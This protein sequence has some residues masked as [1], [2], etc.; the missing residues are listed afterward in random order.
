MYQPCSE[1]SSIGLQAAMAI[2]SSM[3]Y[4]IKKKKKK[5]N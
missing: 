2:D 5:L 3:A 1:Y 4:L